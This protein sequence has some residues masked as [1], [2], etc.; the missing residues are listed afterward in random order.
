MPGGKTLV[1]EVQALAVGDLVF[2]TAPGELFA[3]IGT[4][5]LKASPF[6]HTLVVGYAD[7]YLG[8]LFTDQARKEGGYEPSRPISEEIERPLLAAAEEAMKKAVGSRQ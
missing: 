4:G 8:Y 3:E 5:M 1:T 2:V 7:D 6:G